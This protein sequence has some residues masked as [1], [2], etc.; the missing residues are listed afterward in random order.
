[1]L[2]SDALWLLSDLFENARRT[3]PGQHVL[4]CGR[5]DLVRITLA[6][7]SRIAGFEHSK[8]IAHISNI[9]R[10]GD[11]AVLLTSLK[12]NDFLF[13]EDIDRLSK[14]ACNV[15]FESMESFVMRITVGKGPAAKVVDLSLPPFMIIGGTT[16]PHL[17]PDSFLK[18]FTHLLWIDE[19]PDSLSPTEI[20]VQ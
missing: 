20:V 13:M 7:A 10:G 5:P 1:M 18:S 11:M 19:E 4:L 2:I 15:L 3:Q 12:I 9:E 17:L 16:S 8:F 14:A 6:A